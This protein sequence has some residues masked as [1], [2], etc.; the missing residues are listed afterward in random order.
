M[1]PQDFFTESRPYRIRLGSK[2]VLRNLFYPMAW[3]L[4]LAAH[5]AAHL[6]RADE[7]AV[8]AP[9]AVRATRR[10]ALGLAASAVPW[11]QKC[12]VYLLNTYSQ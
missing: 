10:G 11:G 9:R 4:V 8:L 6:L 2:G 12:I 1:T 7:E 5:A 3:L